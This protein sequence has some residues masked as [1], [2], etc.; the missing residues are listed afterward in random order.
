M[1]DTETSRELIRLQIEELWGR[2]RTELVHEI[3]HPDV[4][5]H[6]PLPDQPQGLDALA[7]VVERFHAAMPDLHI[8][9]H[10]IVAEGERASD[11]WTLTGTHSGTELM[12]VRATGNA[13]RFSGL[14]W[15]R[16]RDGRI[17][18]IWHAEELAL[19]EDQ[20]RGTRHDLG[21]A[22]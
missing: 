19:M 4:V 22:G 5:D 14:D 15:I 6:M 2:K 17:T 10:G 3:Y 8:E 16:A 18:D 1:S 9:V 21:L 13:I 20:V 7:E 12:G 11:F